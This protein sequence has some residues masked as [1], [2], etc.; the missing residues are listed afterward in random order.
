[1]VEVRVGGTAE[2]EGPQADFVQRLVVDAERRVGEVDQLLDGEQDVVRP[3]DGVLH[4]GRRHD[5][6]RV[7]DAVG[8]LLADHRQQ[9]R[10]HARAG[11][12]AQ[13][14]GHL[15][16]LQAVAV[17]GLAT[18]H[19][20]HLVD[21]LG[22]LGVVALGPVVARPVLA[23]DETV[24]AKYLTKLRRPD[25]VDRPGLEVDDDSARDVAL[26]RR[27]VEVHIDLVQLVV[28]DALV[29][30]VGLYAVLPRY[31]FPELWKCAFFRLVCA[32]YSLFDDFDLD[33][34][35]KISENASE[36]T[37]L[38]LETLIKPKM[39]F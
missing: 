28:I 24:R 34:Y 1:M 37:L 5:R 27:L 19:V 2:F 14:V 39:R 25:G 20:E 10:T 21:D 33:Q 32:D 30:A 36:I 6:V 3:D 11:A 35:A 29:R 38:A 7:D 12:T 15:E 22:A 4:L 16:A 23:E 8:V 13:R 26:E 31:H 9:Q 17:F 18:H